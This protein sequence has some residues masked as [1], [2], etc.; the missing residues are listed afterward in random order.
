MMICISGD[1]LSRGYLYQPELTAEKFIANP[2]DKN[3]RLTEWRFWASGRQICK[4]TLHRGR[5]DNR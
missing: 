1:G 4:C 3:S 2:F 5:K